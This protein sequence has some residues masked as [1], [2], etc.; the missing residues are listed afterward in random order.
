MTRDLQNSAE[1]ADGLSR[2]ELLALSPEERGAALADRLRRH[3]ARVLQMPWQ[4]LDTSEPLGSYGLG[5]LKA[6]QMIAGIE[7]RLGVT[8]PTTTAFNY[9]NV[10]ELGRHLG[11]LMEF[12]VDAGVVEPTEVMAAATA[13]L[14]DERLN[15]F[16]DAVERIPISDLERMIA[17]KRAGNT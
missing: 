12:A 10:I 9:P 3:V 15:G 16:L 8:L 17:D 14:E 13:A 4:Q 11:R 5:S 7:E 2:A 6:V 1:E